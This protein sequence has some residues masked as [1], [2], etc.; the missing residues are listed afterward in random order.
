M[1][2]APLLTPRQIAIVREIFGADARLDPDGVV[3]GGRTHPINDGVIVLDGK[4]AASDA[5]KAEVIR[6]F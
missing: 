2:E 6:S 5:A 3:I 1:T 4:V